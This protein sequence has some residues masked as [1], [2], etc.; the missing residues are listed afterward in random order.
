[1]SVSRKDWIAAAVLAGLTFVVFSP[2]LENGFVNFDDYTYVCKNPYVLNGVTT[3]GLRWALTTYQAAN[4]H[5]LTWLSLQLDASLWGREPAGFHRTSVLLHALNA[6]LLFLA[7]RALTGAY[8]RSAAVAV[9]FALHPLRVES[10]AWIAERKDVL[11]ACFGLLALWGYATYAARPGVGRYLVVI[12]ALVLSLLCKPMLVTLPCLLLVLDWWPLGRVQASRDWLRLAVEKVPLFLLVAAFAAVT[13]HVQADQGAIMDLEDSPLTVRVANAAISYATYVGK[14]FWPLKLAAYYPH[15]GSLLQ[16]PELTVAGLVLGAITVA[17]LTL[18]RKAPYLLT[19]WLWFLGTLVPV[20]GLVQVG[21]QAYADR[22]TY[23]PQIGLLIAVCWGVADVALARGPDWQRAAG[24]LLAVTAAAL[25]ILSVRQISV[26]HDSVTL[27]EHSLNVAGR[28]ATGLANLAE[29][30]EERGQLTKAAELYREAIELSPKSAQGYINLGN[31]LQKQGKFDEAAK[32][33]EK[34]IKLMP[35]SPIG[36]TDLAVVRKLQAN[37]DEAARLFEDARTAAPNE[38]ERY[39]NLGM[40]E[41][42]RKD[43]RRAADHYR[44]ALNLQESAQAH[45]GLGVALFRQGQD[46]EDEG[47]AH[48]QKALEIDPE[49]GKCHTLLGK[50][51]LTRKDKERAAWHFEQAVRIS[52]NLGSSWY[53]LGLV[54]GQQGRIVDAGECFLKSIECFAKSGKPDPAAGAVIATLQATIKRLEDQ[55][56]HEHANQLRERLLRLVPQ[57]QGLPPAAPSP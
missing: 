57:L 28:S 15:P 23:F 2:A 52:P 56:L 43:F 55:G 31:N 21:L 18:R 19:G 26:W 6:A 33:F 47:I 50:A 4:W 5:P 45:F 3:S 29:T 14:T 40:I 22:Y 35:N 49:F 42:E 27:W 17:A 20:I 32:Q 38:P 30:L 48:L 37:L 51:L 10:V 12:V 9:L 46:R 36:Y 8:W 53:N 41:E 7:L 34:V 25:A 13:V 16:A 11:S 1:M 54:R 44:S 24:A 39:L